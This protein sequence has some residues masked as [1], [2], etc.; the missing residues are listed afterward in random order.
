MCKEPSGLRAEP[1]PERPNG[2]SPLRR[3]DPHHL[4]ADGSCSSGAHRHTD[5]TPKAVVPV[6][7]RADQVNLR[8]LSPELRQAHSPSSGT[9]PL[10]RTA[11][12]RH[13]GAE[14]RTR[15]PLR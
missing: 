14:E 7:R 3:M 12:S 13:L 6:K 4:A 5:H 8:E 11:V 10:V 2:G 15:E 1:P 9:R